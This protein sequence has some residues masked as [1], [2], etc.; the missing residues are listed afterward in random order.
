VLGGTIALSGSPGQGARFDMVLPR[1]A[2]QTPT[3]G[4]ENYAT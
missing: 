4:E 2:P 3:T 1:V